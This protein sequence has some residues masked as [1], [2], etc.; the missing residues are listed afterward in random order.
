[1][2]GKKFS[3]AASDLFQ[4]LT[5]NDLGLVGQ[6]IESHENGK[7]EVNLSLSVNDEE[8]DVGEQLIKERVALPRIK[9]EA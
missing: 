1:M 5:H 6:V 4:R 3:K 7:L 8:I 2:I 9:E